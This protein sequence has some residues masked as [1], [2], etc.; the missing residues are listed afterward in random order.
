MGKA[1]AALE[2]GSTAAAVEGLWADPAGWGAFLDGFERVVELD[3]DW[4]EPGARL[5]WESH[6][7]GRGRVTEKV[8]RREPGAELVVEQQDSQLSG[9]QRLAFAPVDAAADGRARVGVAL[10]LDYALLRRSPFM[11]V[12]DPLF[13]R[14]ALRDSLR[15]TLERLARELG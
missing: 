5:V 9:V 3:P 13:V 7:G 12:A 2:L 14:R 8:L 11:V 4:P 10:E 1:R 6:P 15:R